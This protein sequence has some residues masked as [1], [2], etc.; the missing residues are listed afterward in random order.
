MKHSQTYTFSRSAALSLV[1]SIAFALL[2]L[3]CFHG[4]RLWAVPNDGPGVTFEFALPVDAVSRRLETI[5]VV[6]KQGR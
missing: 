6:E 1:A 4:G 3:A 5:Q 2:T